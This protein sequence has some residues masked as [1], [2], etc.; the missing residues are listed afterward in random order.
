MSAYAKISGAWKSV[1][2]MFV[3]QTGNWKEVQQAYLK[4]NGTWKLFYA[5]GL[6]LTTTN[7]TA[8]GINNSA[9]YGE[10]FIQPKGIMLGGFL[11]STFR[12]S[13]EF[14]PGGTD[15]VQDYRFEFI[16][17]QD[18]PSVTFNSNL[19]I[20][21]LSTKVVMVL[22]RQAGSNV[23]FNI[24]SNPDMDNNPTFENPFGNWI[25]KDKTDIFRFEILG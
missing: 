11:V 22:G 20:T 23:W 24:V 17:D 1:S 12:M 15:T 7:Y 25:R 3:K 16:F 14:R 8:S 9:E 21:N 6:A 13:L 5:A 19:R 4:Q 2:R 10:V 18:G